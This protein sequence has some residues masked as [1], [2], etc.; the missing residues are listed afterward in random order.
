[1]TRDE[2]RYILDPKDVFGNDF[3]SETFRVLKEKEQKQ[4][5]EYRT[6]R[7]ALAAFDE[8]SRTDRFRGEKRDCTITGKS[9][10]VGE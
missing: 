8:L 7:L 6:Q 4:F 3:P 5:G 1:M 9:R 2:L 10:T